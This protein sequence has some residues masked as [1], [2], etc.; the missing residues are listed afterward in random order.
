MPSLSKVRRP[1]YRA[2]SCREPTRTGNDRHEVPNV[3]DQVGQKWDALPPGRHGTPH[4]RPLRRRQR[5]GRRDRPRHRLPGSH[6]RLRSDLGL[7]SRNP[8][9]LLSRER[10]ESR[11]R[12]RRGRVVPHPPGYAGR[13]SPVIGRSS[14]RSVASDADPRPLRERSNSPSTGRTP[15]PA[16]A[17]DPTTGS[18]N[19]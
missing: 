5:H 15:P 13:S 16:T 19:R 9:H 10:R 11:P 4:P 6:D 17:A 8:H 3:Q 7:D 2:V 1:D 18:P 14:R 12:R